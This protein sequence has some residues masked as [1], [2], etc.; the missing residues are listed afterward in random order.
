M[1]KSASADPKQALALTE[2]A[3]KAYRGQRDKTSNLACARVVRR[4]A[5]YHQQAG[6]PEQA[7]AEFET[8]A[9]DL[10]GRGAN[11]AGRERVPANGK[12]LARRP[13]AIARRGARLRAAQ[14]WRSQGWRSQGGQTDNTPREEEIVVE[15]GPSAPLHGRKPLLSD[16][17][18]VRGVAGDGAPRVG[19][20]ALS[21]RGF[22][23]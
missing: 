21:H 6:N 22:R 10:Q 3:L 18:Q 15:P 4:R 12:Q 14:G 23:R 7:K 2:P 20:T 8:L 16:S 17:A 19:F 1:T 9:K 5:E 11:R 13:G